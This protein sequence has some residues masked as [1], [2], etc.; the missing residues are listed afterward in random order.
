MP[1]YEYR[2]DANAQTLEVRHGMSEVLT[3]W[4]ELASRSGTPLGDTP[5]D[6]PVEK[7]LSP[8]MPM[9]PGAAVPSTGCGAGCACGRPA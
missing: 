4:G 1:Y 7:L 9:T 3:T 8:S 5:A 2:C 6:A